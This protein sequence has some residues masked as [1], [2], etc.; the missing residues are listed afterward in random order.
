RTRH[1]HDRKDIHGLS[2]NGI[3]GGQHVPEQGRSN[4]RRHYRLD[5]GCSLLGRCVFRDQRGIF[6]WWGGAS[7]SERC[8]RMVPLQGHVV[9][10]A[11][12]AERAVV[13]IAKERSKTEFEVQAEAMKLLQDARAE[14]R[15][16]RRI[17]LPWVP[18]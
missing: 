13:K 5:M 1:R 16:S 8:R 12:G 15:C 14:L 9:L 4:I 17:H 18:V 11:N 2:I 6:W 10:P 3:E 7:R